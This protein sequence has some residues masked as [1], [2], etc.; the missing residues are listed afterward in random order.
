MRKQS[1]LIAVILLGGQVLQP[2]WAD[3]GQQN[4]YQFPPPAANT[5]TQPQ[6]PTYQYAPQTANWPLLYYGYPVNSRY[7]GASAY[8]YPHTIPPT[9]M[10][11]YAYPQVY[12]H[13]MRNWN[14]PVQPAYPAPRTYQRRYPVTQ[15]LQRAPTYQAPMY[16]SPYNSNMAATPGSKPKPPQPKKTVKPWGDTRYI[17]PDFYTDFT[18]DFWDEMINAPYNMGYMPG[19][20]RFPSLSS[21]DPVTVGDAVANQMPPILDESANFINFAD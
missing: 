20:W 1:G 6:V 4:T 21:P 12:N 13:T 2:V 9:V 18:G 11:P 8:H 7:H 15:S 19:G 3:Q 5:Q 17:W 10:M 14:Y 16:R